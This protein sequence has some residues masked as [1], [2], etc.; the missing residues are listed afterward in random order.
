MG[1]SF[2]L[3]QL[4]FAFDKN[5]SYIKITILSTILGLLGMFLLINKIGLA[6]SFISIITIE[7]LIII[8]YLLILK[9]YIFV[10]NK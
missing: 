6:G 8:I 9:P 4:I 2:A 10:I 7:F 5:R 3:K 1:I